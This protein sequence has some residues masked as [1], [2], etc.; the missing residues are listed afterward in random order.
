MICQFK[1]FKINRVVKKA[2][3]ELLSITRRHDLRQYVCVNQ[4]KPTLIYFCHAH[5]ILYV[6]FEQCEKDNLKLNFDFS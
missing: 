3:L 5:T 1:R 6:T 4:P 2:A